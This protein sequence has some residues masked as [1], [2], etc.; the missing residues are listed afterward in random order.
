MIH[1]QKNIFSLLLGCLLVTLS[2]ASI[3]DSPKIPPP[4]PVVTP[5]PVFAPSIYGVPKVPSAKPMIDSDL[6]TGKQDAYVPKIVLEPVGSN[7]RGNKMTAKEF[8]ANTAKWGDLYTRYIKGYRPDYRTVPLGPPTPGRLVKPL[9]LALQGKASAEILVDLT[10]ALHKPEVTLKRKDY[11]AEVAVMRNTGHTIVGHAAEELKYWLDTLTGADIPIVSRPRGARTQICVGANFAQQLFA[12]DLTKLGTGEAL[13]GF[14][15]RAR[16]NTVYIF[17]ATAKGTLNG[18]YAFIENNSD[19]IWAHGF[20]DLGTVY[21]VNP[22]LSV[23]WADGLEVPGTIQRGWLGHYTEEEGKPSPF[24]MWQMRNRCNFVVASGPSPKVADWGCWREAGGHC[25]GTFAP[26]RDKDFFPLIKNPETGALAKPEKIEHYQHC[27]CMTH[28]DL[29]QLYAD[30]MVEYIKDINAQVPDKPLNAFRLAIEDPGPEKE[31]GVCYCERCLLPIRLP[32]GQTIPYQHAAKEG[33]TFRSTQF[34]LLLEPIARAVA[35]EF[36][37][38]R[39]S[40]Y[41]YLFT[42]EP[43]PFQT[44]VQPWLSPWGG[45]G[46]LGHRDYKHPIFMGEPG[47]G[48]NWRWWQCAYQWSRMTDLVVLRDYNGV[49]SNGRPF[50]ETLSWDVRALISLGVRRFTNESALNIAFLQMDFWVANRIYWNPE[51][52]VEELRK[53]YI[54]RT[55]REGAPEMAHFFGEIRDWW[56]TQSGPEREDYVNLGWIIDRMGQEIPLHQNLLRALA[57]ARHPVARANIARLLRTYEHWFNL[58]PEGGTV[59]AMLA[60]AKLGRYVRHSTFAH[61]GIPVTVS[62]LTFASSAPQLS[63]NLLSDADVQAA[64]FNGW[65]F[66]M[67]VRPIGSAAA[68]NFSAPHLSLGN[69]SEGDPTSGWMPPV[70]PER[71]KDGSYLYTCQIQAV[72]GVSFVPGKFC[73]VRLEYPEG[74]WREPE[75]YKPEFALYKMSLVDP[76]GKA[77][78]MPSLTAWR[79]NKARARYFEGGEMGDK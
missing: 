67:R 66:S 69:G 42:S 13:D 9:P 73:H 77:Y 22:N 10:P 31:Y 12:A 74:V 23:V 4:K 24:W 63:A 44:S 18:V 65:T 41:A 52:D 20:S 51:A 30:K 8:A 39:F 68:A 55:F 71:Q 35:K 72:P 59:D 50:A 36:P 15:I 45:G 58:N 78:A 49:L 70:A 17:G 25:L 6:S 1:H 38:T 79:G 53:I 75:G 46:Q 32:D 56:Y 47:W 19:L 62:Y 40:T 64:D 3:Y 16:G 61:E 48:S 26:V 34:Y 60:N 27:I 57:Q 28:P 2:P 37:D 29:P 14:A 21:T 7:P 5:T 11:P 43:P 33:L 76:N 54:E